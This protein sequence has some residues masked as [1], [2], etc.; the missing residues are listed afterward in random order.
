MGIVVITS[1][2]SLWDSLVDL[3][4]MVLIQELNVSL[5]TVT[6][7]SSKRCVFDDDDDD[8]EI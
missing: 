4:S 5:A 3:P 1:H 7:T 6:P 8:D 2:E